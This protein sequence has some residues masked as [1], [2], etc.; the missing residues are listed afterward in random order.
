MDKTS[1]LDNVEALQLSSNKNTINL[2]NII[3]NYN[4][5]YEVA[6]VFNCPVWIDLGENSLATLISKTLANGL[7]EGVPLT[8]SVNMSVNCLIGP[9]ILFGISV[10]LGT[11][12]L[13]LF[14]FYSKKKQYVHEN[15]PLVKKFLKRTLDNK[16]SIFKNDKKIDIDKITGQLSKNDNQSNYNSFTQSKTQNIFIDDIYLHQNQNVAFNN[17]P[18]IIHMDNNTNYSI[19]TSNKKLNPSWKIPLSMKT[20]PTLSRP[21][22]NPDKLSQKIINSAAKNTLNLHRQVFFDHIQ[23]DNLVI[24]SNKKVGGFVS[25]KDNFSP[26]WNIVPN[27]KIRLG[28]NDFV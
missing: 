6:K 1:N 8:L 7:D 3:E 18:E 5:K 26:R 2:E 22:K 19:E 21:Y 13:T 9:L 20:S 25:K 27:N 15:K 4:S 16:F 12:I 17:E 10:F 23:P 11:L 24:S 28:S 14:C